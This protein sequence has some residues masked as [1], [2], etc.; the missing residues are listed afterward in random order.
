MSVVISR[1]VVAPVAEGITGG[2]ISNAQIARVAGMNADENNG[3]IQYTIEAMD[4]KYA[5][6][7]KKQ[8][9]KIKAIVCTKNMSNR[10]VIKPIL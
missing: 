2:N 3:L 5:K 7:I 1:L 8:E 9:K 4:K 10:P 6:K